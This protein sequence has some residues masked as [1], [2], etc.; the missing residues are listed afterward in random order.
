MQATHNFME[1]NVVFVD[2]DKRKGIAPFTWYL[3]LLL[4]CSNTT[5]MRVLFIQY[6]KYSG[7]EQ[8]A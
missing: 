1:G 7:V 8:V 3:F 2:G 4:A 5:S 6:K